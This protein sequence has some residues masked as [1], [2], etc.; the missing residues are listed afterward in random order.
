MGVQQRVLCR[1]DR[2]PPSVIF[3]LGFTKATRSTPRVSGEKVK[4]VISTS[5]DAGMV[6]RKHTEIAG[7]LYAVSGLPGIDA[8]D[9]DRLDEVTGFFIPPECVIAAI[10]PVAPYDDAN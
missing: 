7:F 3:A 6:R 4:G 2:R 5:K 9:F 10:G 8:R 1:G